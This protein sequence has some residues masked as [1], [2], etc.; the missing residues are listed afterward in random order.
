MTPSKTEEINTKDK[1]LMTARKLFAEK[2]YDA[3]SVDEIVATAEVNKS[4][5]YYYFKSKQDILDHLFTQYLDESNILK[6]LIISDL[7]ISQED[8]AQALEFNEKFKDTIRIM[9]METLKKKDEAPILIQFFDQSFSSGLKMAKELNIEL[10]DSAINRIMMMF[11][12]TLPILG[13]ISMG[14]QICKY[15]RWDKKEFQ[16][17]FASVFHQ[18]Y[19]KS[20]E[21][22]VKPI[23]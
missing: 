7:S 15:F 13:Y 20:L 19:I 12:A 10:E 21:Q 4:S 18:I 14:D 23:N 5:V 8:I 2:G 22:I 16:E 9:W 17:N 11:M 6:K 3:T 1:I